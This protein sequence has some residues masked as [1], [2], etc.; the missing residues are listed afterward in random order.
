[1]LDDALLDDP[2]A[3]ERADTGGALLALAGAG[4]RIRNALRLADEAGLGAL[5]PDGRP[6]TVLV[7]GHRSALAAGDILAALGGTACPVLTLGPVA[8]AP[9]ESDQAPAHLLDL[10]WYLP[11]W[12]G[13]LDLLVVASD[14]GSEPGLCA[15]IEQAYLRGCSAAVIAPVDSPLAQAAVQARA[16]PLPYATADRARGNDR[17]ADAV[18]PDDLPPEDPGALWAILAP[19]LALAGRIGVAPADGRSLQAAADRL[20]EVAVR[21]RPDAAAYLNPG[22]SLAGRLAGGL[23]LLWGDG[24]LTAAV[25]RRFAALLADR[26]GHPALTGVLPQALAEH[27]GLFAARLGGGTGTEDFFRDRVDEPDPLRLQVLLLRRIIDE[28]DSVPAAP[29]EPEGDTEG[30]PSRTE[31]R[32]TAALHRTVA[33]AQRLAEAHEV[34]LGELAVAHTDPLEALAELVGITDFAAVYL[35]LAGG[36]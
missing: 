26:A 21:C 6:R 5:R 36:A 20:D 2:A 19:L 4:A 28:A 3:L 14:D 34:V 35:G 10:G 15:L 17:G 27:R 24:P 25:A 1:M 16:L 32:D 29:D 22:K 31:D 9:E 33:R 13:S 11:G 23:P 7:A 30:G 8:G 18:T 12:V